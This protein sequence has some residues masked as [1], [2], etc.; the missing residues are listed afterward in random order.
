MV[1]AERIDGDSYEVKHHRR[2]IQHVI[3]PVTPAGK[4]SMKVA[5]DLFGPQVDSA[6]S[7]I[8]MRKLDHSDS[9]LSKKQRQR[10]DPEPYRHAT[11]RGDGR[12]NVEIEHGNHKQQQ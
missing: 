11:I 3:R 8:A 9:L 12:N 2:H 7:G 1:G 4:K 10:D 5:K 6:L